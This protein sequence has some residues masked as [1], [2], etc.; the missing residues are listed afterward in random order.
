MGGEGAK[1]EKLMKL[2]SIQRDACNG[3]GTFA[4]IGIVVKDRLEFRILDD[5]VDRRLW[6]L[7][8]KGHGHHAGTHDSEIGRQELPAVLP[9]KPDTVAGL[10]AASK[11][12][13]CHGITFPVELGIAGAPRRRR[14]VARLD[15][16]GL[17]APARGVKTLAQVF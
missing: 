2:R 5:V 11:Q 12:P 6:Q 8:G 4:G 10:I 7:V 16:R 17:V 1:V 13:A 14:K 9:Q 3:V 15:E